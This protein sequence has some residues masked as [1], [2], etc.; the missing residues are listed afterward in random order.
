MIK[1][2]IRNNLLYPSMFVVFLG[3]RRLVK[4]ILE[5]TYGCQFPFLLA[6]LM[7]FA[8]FVIGGISAYYLNRKRKKNENSKVMGITLIK[9]EKELN[10]KDSDLK[11]I[12]LMI[13]AAVIEF[14]GAVTRRYAIKKLDGKIYYEDDED[15]SDNGDESDEVDGDDERDEGEKINTRLRSFEIIISS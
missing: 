4:A 8:E 13:L 11:I 2:G 9:T 15:T 3:A 1:F 10:R 5:K 7:F 12:L 14:I 6:F